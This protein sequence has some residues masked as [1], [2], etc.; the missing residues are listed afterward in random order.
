MSQGATRRK[1]LG[2][3]DLDRYVYLRI[4]HYGGYVLFWA[5]KKTP[6]GQVFI[7]ELRSYL[8]GNYTIAGFDLAKIKALL[9]LICTQ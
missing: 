4:A 3:T 5:V 1:S 7:G 8:K 6:C 2:T 9:H